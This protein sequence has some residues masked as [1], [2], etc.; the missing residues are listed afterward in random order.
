MNIDSQNIGQD[1]ASAEAIKEVAKNVSLEQ[2][3]VANSTTEIDS[4][5]QLPKGN[6]V[7]AETEARR[8]SEVTPEQIDQAVSEISEFVQAGNRQLNFSID[9][10]SN[11]QIV[12]VTDSQSGEVIRQIPSEEILE[13]SDRLKELTTDV[14]SAVGVLFN[15][16]A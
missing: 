14:G 16:Q 5:A 11:K 9:E 6:S 4:Q 3:K 7:L 8:V 13:L 1:F 15:K 10:D 12:K 2:A